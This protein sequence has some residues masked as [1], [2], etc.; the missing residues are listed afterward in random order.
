MK[1][2]TVYYEGTVEVERPVQSL[3]LVKSQQKCNA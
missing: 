1:S 2:S 3:L